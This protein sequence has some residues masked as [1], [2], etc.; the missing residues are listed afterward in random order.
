MKETE[1]LDDV[2][3][4]KK[5]GFVIMQHARSGLATT[6]PTDSDKRTKPT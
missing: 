5:V 3:T 1:T 4:I 2:L 6:V